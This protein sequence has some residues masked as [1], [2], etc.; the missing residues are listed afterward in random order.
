M[1]TIVGCTVRCALPL[2]LFDMTPIELLPVE[3]IEL[4]IPLTTVYSEVKLPLFKLNAPWIILDAVLV[5]L[6]A[7]EEFDEAI[8][9]GSCASVS[10]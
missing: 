10:V 9:V 1:Q 8:P 5:T 7:C 2:V 3:I 6:I 4:L